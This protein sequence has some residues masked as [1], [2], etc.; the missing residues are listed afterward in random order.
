MRS[1]GSGMAWPPKSKS[2]WCD[3]WAM[4]GDGAERGGRRG[5]DPTVLVE[6]RLSWKVRPR[7]RKGKYHELEGRPG[8]HGLHMLLPEL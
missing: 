1:L 8:L 2:R 5:G 7:S 6:E 3:G 4:V